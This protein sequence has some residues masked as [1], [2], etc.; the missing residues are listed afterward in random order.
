MC[1]LP[2]GDKNPEVTRRVGQI[3]LKK[4]IALDGREKPWLSPEVARVKDGPT[5][6]FN[7]EPVQGESKKR[8]ARVTGTNMTEPGQ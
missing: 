2:T 1:T 8:K 7:Q 5:G 4:M 3:R 6:A